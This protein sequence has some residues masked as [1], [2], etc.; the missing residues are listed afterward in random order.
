MHNSFCITIVNGGAF[1]FI[2]ALP[3]IFFNKLFCIYFA[4]VFVSCL[5]VFFL[6]SSLTHSQTAKPLK[7]CQQKISPTKSN[8]FQ[9]EFKNTSLLSLTF[10]FL[11]LFSIVVRLEYLFRCVSVCVCVVCV[12]CCAIAILLLADCCFWCV[13]FSFA[14]FALFSIVCWLAYGIS[15]PSWWDRVG[16]NFNSTHTQCVVYHEFVMNMPH[17]HWL[18]V[19]CACKWLCPNKNRVWI[20]C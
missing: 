1:N 11:L 6:P 15:L 7:T 8:P 19:V 3:F 16:A 14:K 10:L 12:K 20:R 2:Y 4:C 18:C 17:K 5:L 9:P 13:F